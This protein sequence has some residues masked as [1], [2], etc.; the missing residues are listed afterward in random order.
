MLCRQAPGR[1]ASREAV[2]V[3]ALLSAPVLL[4]P[5]ESAGT[6]LVVVGRMILAN[7]TNRRGTDGNGH[8]H[9]TSYGYTTLGLGL[10]VSVPTADT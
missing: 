7:E 2:A 1:A 4:D 6:A 9:V 10:G 5:S 3:S 8:T